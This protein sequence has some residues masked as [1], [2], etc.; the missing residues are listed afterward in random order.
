IA[1]ARY[2]PGQKQTF[3]VDLLDEAQVVAVF[4]KIGL[5]SKSGDEQDVQ[6]TPEQMEFRLHLQDGTVAEAVPPE[7]V[8]K[9]KEQVVAKIAD[10]ALQ[11]GFLKL[12]GGVKE[13]FVY[14]KLR[15]K[16]GFE[17]DGNTVV[18]VVGDVKR[19]IDLSRSLLSF[20][21]TRG[22]KA[23]PFFIGVAR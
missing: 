17:I 15:P 18:H 11:H 14:F 19:E 13:G 1:E 23:T 2:V 8:F 4:V 3:G 21:L 10:K 5:P 9:G 22:G 20:Q 12:S 7:S 6:L 16:D